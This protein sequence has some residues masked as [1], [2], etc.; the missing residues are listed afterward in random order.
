MPQ[1]EEIRAQLNKPVTR[2]MSIEREVVVDEANRTVQL[3]FASDTPCETWFGD[4]VLTMTKKAVRTDRL[5]A[6]LALLLDH[7]RTK[8]IGKRYFRT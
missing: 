7:D 2:S 5:D 6:G 1:I 4:L 3:A 8:Q